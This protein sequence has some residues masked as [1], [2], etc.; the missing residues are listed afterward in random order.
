M[1]IVEMFSGIGSQAKA[2]YRV[3]ERMQKKIE[4]TTTCEWNI[5]AFVAYNYIHNGTIISDEISLLRKDELVGVLS[6]YSISSDGIAPINEVYLKSLP[7]DLL[8]AIYQS[9]MNNNNLINIKEVKGSDIPNDTDLL[10]YSFPCQDLSNV[11]SFHGYK[12]GI[13]KNMNTRSGLLWEIERILQEKKDKNEPLPKFLLLENVTA[14]EAKRHKGN[15]NEWKDKLENLGYI[16]KVY[17]LNSLDFGI[18]QNRNRLIMLSVYVGDNK[19]IESLV[20]NYWANKDLNSIDFVKSLNIKAL[21]L[22]W[23]LRTDYNQN[24]QLN[25]A[26]LSQPRA[27]KSRAKIWA[28]N[29]QILNDNGVI[30][31]KVQTITTKQD[32]HPNSGNLFFDPDNDKA[33]YRFLTPRECFLLMGFD[34]IDYEILINNNYITRGNALFFSRDVLYKLAGNS[35]VVN[36]LEHVFEQLFEINDLIRPSINVSDKN[37]IMVDETTI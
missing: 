15:F 29:Y 31:D 34:E 1:K 19:N 7:V 24:Y 2:L 11:G 6:K 21:P 17:K 10:T 23:Y 5:H 14:L 20:Y 36:V 12:Y 33:R 37:P 3:A 16:N 26:L 25:E 32:R 9:I 27:T 4:I 18:P 22:N 8:R 30:L 35:I 13:D 28:E